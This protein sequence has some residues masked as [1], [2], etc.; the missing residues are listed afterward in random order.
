MKNEKK[1]FLKNE[2]ANQKMDSLKKNPYFASLTPGIFLSQRVHFVRQDRKI[3][4]LKNLMMKK[5]IHCLQVQKWIL[6]F[7][8]R[9][10]F[11]I[12]WVGETKKWTH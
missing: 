7:L 4:S 12:L 8:A 11:F 1:C 6:F 5:K 9:N 3:D 10:L 2:F